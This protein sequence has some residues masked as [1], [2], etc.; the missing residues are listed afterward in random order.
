MATNAQPTPYHEPAIPFAEQR[1][2]LR[3]GIGRRIGEKLDSSPGLWRLTSSPDRPVQLYVRGNFLTPSECASLCQ[4]IDSDTHPSP[5]Y[6]KDKYQ[7]V[8]TSCSCD[9]NVRDPLV[10]EV[11]RRIAALLGMDPAQGEPLQGQRYQ[12]GQEFK[13]HSDFFY[14]DQPYWE[15][16]QSHGGQRTWTAMIYLNTVERGGATSFRYLDLSIAPLSGRLIIWNNMALDG[17]PNPWTEHAG[18]PVEAS[19]KYVVTKWYRERVFA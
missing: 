19:A 6:E 8:R 9:L 4:Q 14:I 13:Y 17:S 3:A 7:G 10:S 5:L 2:D 12:V 15:E 11:D 1:S 16:Y 18:L